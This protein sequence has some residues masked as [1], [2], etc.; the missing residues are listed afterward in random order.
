[1]GKVMLMNMN[2]GADFA[3]FGAFE[4]V[5][6]KI[7]YVVNTPEYVNAAWGNA[8]KRL[9]IEELKKY[10]DAKEIRFRK[11]RVYL[12]LNNEVDS[13]EERDNN[14][15][16]ACETSKL[17]KNNP[18]VIE[19]EA[20]NEFLVLISDP[21]PATATAT[22]TAGP[23]PMMPKEPEGPNVPGPCFRASVYAL[24]SIGTIVAMYFA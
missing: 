16:I 14:I 22:S 9:V 12:N 11:N 20:M 21:A 17:H 15:L 13:V 18:L 6:A 3:P 23:L 1:M 5:E 4:S 24:L 10:P 8:M 2:V 19:A 7:A